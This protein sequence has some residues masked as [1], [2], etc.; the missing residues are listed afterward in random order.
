VTDVRRRRKSPN[1]KPTGCSKMDVKRLIAMDLAEMEV[2]SEYGLE[3]LTK[4]THCY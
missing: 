3:P 1:H 4:P 2:I